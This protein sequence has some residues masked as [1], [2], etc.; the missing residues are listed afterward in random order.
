MVRQA[1]R[2]ASSG[3]VAHSR[4]PGPRRS[5]LRRQARRYQRRHDRRSGAVLLPAELH[6]HDHRR[7]LECPG[8]VDGPGRWV[9]RRP[10]RHRRQDVGRPARRQSRQLFDQQ[11]RSPAGKRCERHAAPDL[12]RHHRRAAHDPQQEQRLRVRSLRHLLQHDADH[13]HAQH[14]A[15][16]GPDRPDAPGNDAEPAVDLAA[17]A[18]DDA[19][20]QVDQP[21]DAAD[22]AEP[23]EHAPD[24][25]DVDAAH[26]DHAPDNADANA[27]SPRDESEPEVDDT[28]PAG[29]FA[30]VYEPHPHRAECLH[31]AADDDAEPAQHDS[32]TPE[33]VSTESGNNAAFAKHAAQQLHADIDRQEHEPDDE[34]H[35][36]LLHP[37]RAAIRDDEPEAAA[38]DADPAHVEPGVGDH[39]PPPAQHFATDAH[40]EP[41]HQIHVP[42]K[43]V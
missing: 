7:L 15:I 10:G 22:R 24:P 2:T 35:H 9:H 41:D 8:R 34:R 13:A 16:A 14:V 1:V 40:D 27:N 4:G 19:D 18:V 20:A 31:P 32:G 12:G 5:S 36:P 6:H 37:H 29:Q 23:Q 43:Q 25:R 42:G 11:P 33:H 26:Q 28:E 39:A 3:F 21:A 30:V 38:Y 17:P